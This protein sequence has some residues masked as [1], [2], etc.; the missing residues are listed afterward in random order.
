MK[1]TKLIFRAKLYIYIFTLSNHI[2]PN[3]KSWDHR[4]SM[5]KLNGFWNYVQLKVYT[6]QQIS[7]E[8]SKYIAW[9]CLTMTFF[10]FL[11]ELIWT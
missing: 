4:M 6:I 11:L 3:D 2:M 7:D 10:E 9:W 5:N 8:S 1:I